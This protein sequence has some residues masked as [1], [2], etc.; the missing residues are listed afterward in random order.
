M[1]KGLTVGSQRGPGDLRELLNS[2]DVPVDSFLEDLKARRKWK[3][4]YEQK[5]N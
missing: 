3:R 2:L 5:I 4:E 1:K